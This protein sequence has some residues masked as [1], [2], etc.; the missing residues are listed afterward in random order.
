[1]QPR[2]PGLLWDIADA[3][4]FIAAETAGVTFETYQLDRRLRHA[5]ERD[6][7]IIGEA[8]RRLVEHDPATAARISGVPQIIAFRNVLAHGYDAVVDAKVWEIIRTFLPVLLSEV[9]ALLEEETKR[10]SST[11]PSQAQEE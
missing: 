8:V 6:F 3:G 7:E 2:T 4:G 1:M 5:V 9:T 10:D 11:S